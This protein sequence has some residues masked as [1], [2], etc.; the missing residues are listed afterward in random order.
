MDNVHEKL[1][2]SYTSHCTGVIISRIMRWARN[3]ACMG[4]MGNTYSILV[5]KLENRRSLGRAR[6]RWKVNI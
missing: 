1:R 4:E 2:S 6:R 5:V 3:V